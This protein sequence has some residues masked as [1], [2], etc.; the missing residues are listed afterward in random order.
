MKEWIIHDKP[1]FMDVAYVTEKSI[2]DELDRTSKAEVKTMIISYL[3]MF[4]YIS[5]A[6]GKMRGSIRKCFVIHYS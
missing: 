4:L 3:L 5:F 6:L 2:Q 1:D